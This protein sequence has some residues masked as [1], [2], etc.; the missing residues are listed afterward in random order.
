MN[1]EKNTKNHILS[2]FEKLIRKTF[3]INKFSQNVDLSIQEHKGL[4]RSKLV[5]QPGN[6]A[7][8]ISVLPF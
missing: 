5:F 8:F 7:T 1:T 2:F 4:I 6:L 3:S